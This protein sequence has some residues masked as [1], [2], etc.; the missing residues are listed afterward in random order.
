MR[1]ALRRQ[2]YSRT[3]KNGLLALWYA[4]HVIDVNIPPCLPHFVSIGNGLDTVADAS[5]KM[6]GG[7]PLFDITVMSIFKSQPTNLGETW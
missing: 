6:L 4:C 7:V 5:D 3:T 2:L 1:M